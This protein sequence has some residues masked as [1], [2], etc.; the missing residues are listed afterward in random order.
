MKSSAPQKKLTV[1]ACVVDSTFD[2]PVMFGPVKS[3]KCARGK[4]TAGRKGLLFVN[5]HVALPFPEG[6]FSQPMNCQPPLA[7]GAAVSVTLA[8]PPKMPV[9]CDACTQSPMKVLLITELMHVGYPAG[10]VMLPAP[11]IDGLATTSAA[12]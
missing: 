3:R 9:S 10:P 11:W 7:R 1:R 4:K 6:Q 12:L 8:T 2:R 5:V